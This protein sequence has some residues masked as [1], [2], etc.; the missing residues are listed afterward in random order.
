MPLHLFRVPV[1]H[2][3]RLCQPGVAACVGRPILLTAHK[4]SHKYSYDILEILTLD[5]HCE[6]LETKEALLWYALI[7]E[8]ESERAE[9]SQ[10]ALD[11]D[12]WW[13][14]WLGRTEKR[15]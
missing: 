8:K 5:E 7:H 14:R 11:E 10:D 9:G 13:K 1:A 15:E 3:P 12:D 4:Y 6:D 2:L